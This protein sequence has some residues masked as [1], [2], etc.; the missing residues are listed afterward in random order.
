LNAFD[1][2]ASFSHH[3]KQKRP[4]DWNRA[5]FEERV[6]I[7]WLLDGQSPQGTTRARYGMPG[8]QSA[9]AGDPM[10]Q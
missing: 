2:P 5:A 3:V 4:Q 10:V 6:L 8:W 7:E 1:K 9:H